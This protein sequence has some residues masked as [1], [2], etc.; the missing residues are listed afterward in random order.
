M[1]LLTSSTL[2]LPA[3][4]WRWPKSVLPKERAGQRACCPYGIPPP[5]AGAA[6]RMT[7]TD[8]SM[9]ACTSSTLGQ[10]STVYVLSSTLPALRAAVGADHGQARTGGDRYGRG[11][12]VAV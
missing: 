9:T 2:G 11:P 10:L 6:E 7:C 12:P 5:S 8:V 1:R 3:S 4:E